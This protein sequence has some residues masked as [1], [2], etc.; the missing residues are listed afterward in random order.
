MVGFSHCGWGLP[1]E[2]HELPNYE[3][4]PFDGI[5]ANEYIVDVVHDACRLHLGRRHAGR[6]GAEHLV[7]HAQLR[8]PLPD[9]RRDRL[10]LHLRRARRPGPRLRQAR[11]RQA[12][13]RPLVRGDQARP[14][15]R[16][17]RHE[18]PGR[19]PGRR[20]R[21]RRARAASCKLD[22]P[23]TV[24]V[25]VRGRRLSRARADPATWP[26]RRA[27]PLDEQPYWDVERARIGT[28]RTVPVEVVVNGDAV[29]TRRDRRRR[30]RSRTSSSTSRSSDRAGSPCGSTRRRT[31][32]RSS[33]SSTA[34]RS[35]PRRSRPSG[36]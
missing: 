14:I 15:V 18:P 20:R 28:T 22:K 8:L 27:R 21:G 9:Q 33:S 36:A 25:K 17:R 1:D 19:L 32:T 31:P 11:R 4:P 34:S 29:A 23:G 24:K 16:L 3:M 12:R 2:G 35:G 10:P 5:G 7:S 30:H 26:I 6:L 13:L